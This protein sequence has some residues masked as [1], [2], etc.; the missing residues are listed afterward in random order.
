MNYISKTGP[1]SP[2]VLSVKAHTLM[3][4]VSAKMAFTPTP[5]SPVKKSPIKA[6]KKHRT[7]EHRVQSKENHTEL[8]LANDF[9]KTAI[10]DMNCEEIEKV[11]LQK[12]IT[13]LSEKLLLFQSIEEDRS[14][15]EQHLMHSEQARVDLQKV[16]NDTSAKTKLELGKLS[17]YQEIMLQENLAVSEQLSDHRMALQSKEQECDEALIKIG[18]Q[19]KETVS[20]KLQVTDLQ[21]YKDRYDQQAK[22]ALHTKETE[23]E[24]LHNEIESISNSH[25]DLIK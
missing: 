12:A 16:L 22:V 20:L 5:G 17:Q 10:G 2:S 8:Q 15:T 19:T 14:T 13:A 7:T 3:P 23:I 9:F 24:E 21:A 11:Q 25:R 18:L 1:E 4:T 6:V